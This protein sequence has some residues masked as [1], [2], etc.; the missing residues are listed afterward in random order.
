MKASFVLF[1]SAAADYQCPGGPFIR[2][3]MKVTATASASCS[4]VRAEIAARAQ[5]STAGSWVDPHNGGIYSLVSNDNGV[6]QTERSTNQGTY[7][8]AGT[9][10]V[11]KQT[12]V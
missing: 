7:M 9:T 3:S 2:A 8:P 6:I 11:D 10:Y 1:A 5:A 4:D 12:Y